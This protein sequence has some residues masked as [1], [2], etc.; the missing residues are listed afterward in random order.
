MLPQEV[1]NLIAAGRC[2]D[3]ENYAWDLIRSI[4]AVAVSGEAAGCA[5]AL[6]AKNSCTTR[7]LDIKLLQQTIRSHGGHCS[8]QEINLPYR[9][10]ES[11]IEPVWLHSN[12]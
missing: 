5:A 9:G 7:T 1:D 8:M 6:C 4:P 11:Y 12:H 3:A 2:I 10:D